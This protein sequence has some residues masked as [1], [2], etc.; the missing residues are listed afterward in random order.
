MAASLVHDKETPVQK[1]EDPKVSY[2]TRILIP[3]PSVGG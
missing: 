2:D 1:K 3:L